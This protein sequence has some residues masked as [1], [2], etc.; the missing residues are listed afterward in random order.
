MEEADEG[1]KRNALIPVL[2]DAVDPP[3][4]FRSIQAANL[5]NLGRRQPS[6]QLN[7]FVDTVHRWLQSP[8]LQPHREIPVAASKVVE[9]GEGTTS[10]QLDQTTAERQGLSWPRISPA[11]WVGFAAVVIGA[12]VFAAIL[13]NQEK[14]SVAKTRLPAEKPASTRVPDAT[15]T[16]PER[17]SAPA[18]TVIFRDGSR[19]PLDEIVFRPGDKVC[20]RGEETRLAI[21]RA[22]GI[23]YLMTDRESE[24]ALRRGVC[25]ARAISR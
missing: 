14:S 10:A 20:Y 2:L 19:K 3:L 17:V 18:I 1:L 5:T 6:P 13:R 4:G 24:I 16:R 9:I 12:L 22:G 8:S 23:P 15:S 21:E 7:E 11:L 25:D